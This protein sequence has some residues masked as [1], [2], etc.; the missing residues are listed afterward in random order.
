MSRRVKEEVT[1]VAPGMYYYRG[2]YWSALSWSKLN[3]PAGSADTSH[4]EE[5][6]FSSA[7]EPEATPRGD[8]R[9]TP[10]PVT[11]ACR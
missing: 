2:R 1:G 3:V 11:A 9:R 10:E 8:P 6:G 5:D 4:S 7:A